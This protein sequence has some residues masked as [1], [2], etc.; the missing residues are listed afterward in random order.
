MKRLLAIS[1]LALTAPAYAQ[2]ANN[3]WAIT[4]AIVVIGDGGEPIRGG[5]VV[6]RGGKV[7]AAGAGVAVPVVPSC[8]TVI[9]ATRLP[10][11]AASSSS[12][13]ASSPP[14]MPLVAASPA[15]TMSTGPLAG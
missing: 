15:P 4:N 3:S 9:E 7:V 12:A 8:W 1:A 14:T 13:P 10:T 5:T 6:V 11:A 2:D